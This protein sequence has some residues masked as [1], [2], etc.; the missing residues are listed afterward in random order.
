MRGPQPTAEAAASSTSP[1]SGGE[2]GGSLPAAEAEIVALFADLAGHLGLPKS[3]GQIFGLAYATP[4]PVTFSD[5]VER[6]GISKGSASQGLRF[7]REL[8]ALKAVEV[9]GD[10]REHFAPELSLRRLL[11]GVLEERVQQPLVAG[12]G[13]L[14]AL[15]ARVAE[16]P[17]EAGVFLRQRVGSLRAWQR[18]ARLFLP[19]LQTFLGSKRG[20]G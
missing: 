4:G 6:L 9:P 12:E 15:E 13:R 11:T 20:S 7:L 1:T 8:G 19:F 17:G 5:L 14:A 16:I 18:K 2:E 3:V 10:R